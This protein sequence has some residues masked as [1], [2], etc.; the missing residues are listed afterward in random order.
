MATVTDWSKFQR[1]ELHTL[2]KVQQEV[3][4][5][6]STYLDVSINALKASMEEDE[7]VRVVD[8]LK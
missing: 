3:G 8:A 7:V 6:A 1:K 2:L 5:G 4:E